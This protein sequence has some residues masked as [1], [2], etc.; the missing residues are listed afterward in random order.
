MIPMCSQVAT[1]AP[2]GC[3]VPDHSGM[4]HSCHK[5]EPAAQRK[6]SQSTW[7]SLGRG[8]RNNEGSPHTQSLNPFF[9][10]SPWI[11]QLRFPTVWPS[12]QTLL[13][14]CSIIIPFVCSISISPFSS[15]HKVLLVY[16]VERHKDQ[17]PGLLQSGV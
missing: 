3:R 8:L 9:R 16:S 11:S 4:S 2:Q 7:S 5:R 15:Q 14:S 13:L 6:T 10:F 17:A 1:R 12:P